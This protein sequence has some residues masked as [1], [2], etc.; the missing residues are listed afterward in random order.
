MKFL[1]LLLTLATCLHAENAIELLKE[2]DKAR[3]AV[4]DGLTWGLTIDTEED[5]EASSACIDLVARTSESE[6]EGGTLPQLWRK[7]PHRCAV[8]IKA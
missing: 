8:P 4:G 3:G 5:G 7:G 1:L 2:S 6:H